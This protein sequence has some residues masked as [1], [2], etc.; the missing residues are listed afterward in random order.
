MILA[1]NKCVASYDPRTGAQDWIIDGPTEQYVAS[2]VYN[3]SLLFMTAGFPEHHILAIK[4][5]GTG[6]VTKSAIVQRDH[7]SH[8]L[9]AFA[10]RDRRLFS[11]DKRRRNRQLL[12]GR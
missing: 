3:G 4:P 9:C 1:G 8:F 5:D 6:N 2:M 11:G 10:D 12:C 7:A